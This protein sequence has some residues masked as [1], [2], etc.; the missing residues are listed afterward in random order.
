M[1]TRFYDLSTGSTRKKLQKSIFMKEKNLEPHQKVK[2]D[3]YNEDHIFSGGPFVFRRD[4]LFSGGTICFQEGQFVFR[5][6]HLFSGGTIC[7]PEGPFVFRRD[8]LFSGGLGFWKTYILGRL[9]YVYC[10]HR[11]IMIEKL[12][13]LVPNRARKYKFA[14]S[15]S[16]TTSFTIYSMICY[17]LPLQISSFCV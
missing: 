11:Y 5:R 6:D 9:I 15:S 4:H 3:A 1:V 2:K 14:S 10:L 12:V 13:V 16:Y 17:N 7:F 8:H